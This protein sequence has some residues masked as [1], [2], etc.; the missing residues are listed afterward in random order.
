MQWHDGMNGWGYGFTTIGL[1]LFWGLVILA[2]IVLFRY[3]SRSEQRP[4]NPP[5]AGPTARDVLAER[6]ARGEIDAEQY[7]QR[8]ATLDGTAHAGT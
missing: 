2:G 8:L 1:V 3:L 7:R 5:K 6:F 4:V